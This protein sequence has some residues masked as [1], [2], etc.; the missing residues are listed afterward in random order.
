MT[1]SQR[2][3]RRPARP[4]LPVLLVL[5]LAT[6]AL[7]CAEPSTDRFPENWTYVGEEPVT[8]DS[9]MVVTTD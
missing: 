6:G 5:L 3:K 9:G 8:A 1:M 2:E 7:A 4:L